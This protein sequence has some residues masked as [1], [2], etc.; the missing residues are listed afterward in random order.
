MYE[1]FMHFFLHFTNNITMLILQI[2]AAL[3]I[4]FITLTLTASVELS[5]NVLKNIGV[6]KI[7]VF[8]V[9]T[10]FNSRVSVV[11]EYLNFSNKK[12]K[13]VK[14]KLDINDRSVQYFNELTKYIR[15]KVLPLKL[16]FVADI[17]SENSSVSSLL[18]GFIN[19]II[20][21]YYLTISS[22]RPDM[23]LQREINTGF[24]HNIIEFSLK[25]V[26]VVT[27]YDLFW[28]AVR[29]TLVLRRGNEKQKTEKN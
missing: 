15:T 18:S 19:V 13:I 12:S 28:S 1:M 24:R 7:R 16:V 2:I 27:L 14:I 23:L 29:S 8:K 4:I 21:F 9:I 5:F 26:F 25:F 17:C 20:S 22:K 6:L 10:I 11:D 3:L